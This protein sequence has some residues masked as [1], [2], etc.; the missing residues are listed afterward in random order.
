MIEWYRRQAA[1]AAA[2]PS[3]LPEW[4]MPAGR[5]SST[6]E[7]RRIVGTGFRERGAEDYVWLTLL[8]DDSQ[9]RPLVVV[10]LPQRR[11]LSVG[12]A[13]LMGTLPLL[14]LVERPVLVEIATAA[15]RP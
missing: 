5:K 2:D 15:Q 4:M 1:E 8:T 9:G 7:V 12:V 14:R 13:L 10:R 6:H 3:L 11:H